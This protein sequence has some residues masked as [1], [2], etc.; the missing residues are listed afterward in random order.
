MSFMNPVDM[1]DED[2][3]DLQFPKEK[4]KALQIQRTP[5]KY[6][7]ARSDEKTKRLTV[8]YNANAFHS[9]L[10]EIAAVDET[11]TS[12]NCLNPRQSAETTC[13]M[14]RCGIVEPY[15]KCYECLDV[16][17]CLPCFARGRQ[18]GAHRNSHAYIIVRDDI[19][20]FASE[21]GW[22]SRDERTLLQALRTHGYGNWTA[23]AGAL[24]GRRHGPEEIQRH[25]HDCYFGGIFERLLGLQHAR[26][27]YLPERMPYVFKMRSLEPPRHDDIASI[28]FKINAGYRCARGDFDT[29][30][31]ASAEGLLTVMLEQQ[32]VLADDELEITA[33]DKEVV[34]EL[35]CALVHAY[36]NRL[37]ER[38]RRYSIMRK[39]GLIM[40][41]RTV[42]WITK[43]VNAFRSDASCMRFLALMQV[44]QPIDFDKLVESLHYYRQLQNR[45]NW[46]H[47]LRQHGVRT[48]HGGALYARLHKQRQQAQ[49]DYMRQ[50]Q[51]DA[52]DWQQLVHHYEHNQNAELPL[53]SSSRMYMFYPRRKASPIEISDLPGYSKLEAGERTLCSV[54]RLIPQAYLEYKNQLIAEQSK[55][56]HLR[57]AD[58][59]RLI[60]IDV[61]KTRRI[62]DF[63]VK[64]GHIRPQ[65]FG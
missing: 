61:N 43:Y 57:L 25:Y 51:N 17:L 40:P 37:R 13:A 45:L 46:L 5:I 53:G 54:E 49:R 42:S 32:R 63:L 23:V 27:C 22:T 58:A 26:N 36:N 20:V 59:R 30:Y 10:E 6:S 55:L 38:Q 52:Q 18:M 15:I 4:P 3:A 1:V 14:C 48:L 33:S 2:A 9:R 11:S 62:Y 34:E 16:L 28:Q 29:P 50:R 21:P 31:D 47:D 35:Q 8:F 39:H 64:N 7:L 60:K 19:Q 12:N 44:C 41:N 56:G 65:T 24:D